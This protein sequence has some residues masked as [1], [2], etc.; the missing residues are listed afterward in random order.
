MADR[1][2]ITRRAVLSG[3]A[4]L[5]AAGPASSAAAFELAPADP[6]VGLALEHAALMARMAGLMDASGDAMPDTAET[7]PLWDRMADIVAAFSDSAPLT[8]AGARGGLAVALAE[9]QGDCL[10]DNAFL[11]SVL[12]AALDLGVPP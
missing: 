11:V 10:V 9:A 6:W 1:V 3:S 2:S 5:L 12:G 7:G 4:A 8:A